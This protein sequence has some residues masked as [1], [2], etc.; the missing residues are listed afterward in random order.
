MR[1][2]RLLLRLGA[3]AVFGLGLVET[4]QGAPSAVKWLDEAGVGQPQTVGLILALAITVIFGAIA[5]GPAR[6]KHWLAV[7]RGEEAT[8]RDAPPLALAR[9]RER[10]A[11]LVLSSDVAQWPHGRLE[12]AARRLEDEAQGSLDEHAPGSPIYI[13]KGRMLYDPDAPPP[14]F[15]AAFRERARY[16]VDRLDAALAGQ[17]GH[18]EIGA[19]RSRVAR[20]NQAE[21]EQGSAAP[22]ERGLR[23]LDD[24]IRQQWHEIKG[25]RRAQERQ[26]TEEQPENLRV[27]AFKKRQREERE[28][29]IERLRVLATKIEDHVDAR[30][31]VGPRWEPMLFQVQRELAHALS[32][33]SPERR[34]Y[35]RQLAQYEHETVARYY[36]IIRQEA[37]D[38]METALRLGLATDGQ[39]EEVRRPETAAKLAALPRML[40]ETADLLGHES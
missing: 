28:P 7:A 37:V 15:E 6:L 11:S 2:L 39:V 9:M 8:P 32:G 18:I 4:A 1:I 12:A 5:L 33:G 16:V 19:G 30:A 17:R 22:L 25:E 13:D 29:I 36:L 21:Q 3:S 35:E 14:T 26:R 38:A 24:T 23:E 40:R 31:A 20:P 10:A 34:K 27:A